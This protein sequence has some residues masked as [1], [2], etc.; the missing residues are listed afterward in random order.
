MENCEVSIINVL[1][2]TWVL[3]ISG[4]LVNRSNKQV[5]AQ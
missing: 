4:W 2:I 3:I 5:I 1:G